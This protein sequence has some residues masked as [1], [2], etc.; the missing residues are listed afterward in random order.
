[1]AGRLAV[2]SSS[3]HA[4]L[5]GLAIG[6]QRSAGFACCRH[7]LWQSSQIVTKRKSHGL[8]RAFSKAPAAQK[9]Q[10]ASAFKNSLLRLTGMQQAGYSL[11]HEEHWLCGKALCSGSGRRP[12]PACVRSPAV[13]LL[14]GK[15]S[16]QRGQ[17]SAPGK[18]ALVAAC[19][20]A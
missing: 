14:A 3:V 9:T 4:H 1:L 19:G 12:A 5:P 7:R 13:T 6:Q 11:L 10:A 18:Q 2:S 16:K 15:K 8:R 17:S 20:D